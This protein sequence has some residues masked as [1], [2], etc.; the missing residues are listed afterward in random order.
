MN[1]DKRLKLQELKVVTRAEEE[2]C[3]VSLVLLLAITLV[4]RTM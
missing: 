3:A 1:T 4:K 2:L